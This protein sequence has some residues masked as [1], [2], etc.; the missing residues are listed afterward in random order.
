[1]YI[2]WIHIENYRNLE[3]V[4]ISFH[5]K[6]NYFVGRNLI[7]KSNF[8]DLLANIIAG[9]NFKETDFTNPQRML[10]ITMQVFL[11]PS[12]RKIYEEL[13]TNQKGHTITLEIEQLIQEVH[14]R[15]YVRLPDNSR[16]ERSL[17]LF[18]RIIYICHHDYKATDLSPE[19]RSE[20]PNFGNE[21]AKL[22]PDSE[23]INLQDFKVPLHRAGKNF[24][25]NYYLNIERLIELAEANHSANMVLHYTPDNI[26]LVMTIALK[27]LL[28]IYVKSK[29]MAINIDSCVVENEKGQRLLPI[30]I[31]VDEPEIHLGPYLQRSLLKCYRQIVNNEN[32]E[33][34][35]ILKKLFNVDGLLGQLF[36]ITNSTD[37][38]VDDYRNIIRFY[39]NDKNKVR[40]ACG[41]SFHFSADVEKH[42]VMHFPEAK[43]ALFARC[44]II[45][46]GET[47]YG[48]FRGFGKTLGID[49]DYYGICLI[50]A[51]GESSI[52]KLQQLF[53]SFKVPTIVLYDQD[54]QE[55][56]GAQHNPLIMFT[57]EICYEMDLV[58]HV[59]KNHHR[60]L[61][62]DI[63]SLVAEDKRGFVNSEML[64][65]GTS[66]LKYVGRNVN[67]RPL[68]NIHD[69]QINELLLYYF[70]W[71]YSNKGVIV[72]RQISLGLPK[73]DI[74]RAFVRVIE[75]AREISLMTGEEHMLR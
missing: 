65:K 22:I 73:E 57:D 40:V 41:S 48:S 42:L 26:H 51:R 27:I 23:Q 59:I 43:E 20:L 45:V 18:R 21:L 16:E 35:H 34:L 71:F 36:I 67:P 12:E 15:F 4:E 39:R 69:N 11:D 7:G 62:D 2:Q 28:Q 72:G 50:N 19:V 61:L 49:F 31:C 46:E 14:P 29:S 55:K 47:E 58:K 13:V 25:L 1:M 10:R 54:V 9:D 75:Q 3:N 8:L 5:E 66:K 63:I 64:R 6:Y 30:I 68:R 60:K 37:A 44:L 70:S 38:L 17:A 33:F 32:Q 74:P 53:N 24:D 56:Y 52:A